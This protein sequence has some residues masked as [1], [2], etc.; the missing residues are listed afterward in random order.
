MI[1]PRRDKGARIYF[2]ALFFHTDFADFFILNLKNNLPNLL[3]LLNL[4]ETNKLYEQK[5]L[6]ALVS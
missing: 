2:F 5:K 1:L 4:R 3:N 6:R